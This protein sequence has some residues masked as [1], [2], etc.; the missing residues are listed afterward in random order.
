MLDLEPGADP[1]HHAPRICAL[2][3]HEP[4]D[5]AAQRGGRGTTTTATMAEAASSGP[6]PSGSS[7]VRPVVSPPTTSATR[8]VSGTYKRVRRS[9]TSMPSRR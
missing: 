1:V 8:T 3:E 5:H 9:T 4:V 6:G 2:P 7:R